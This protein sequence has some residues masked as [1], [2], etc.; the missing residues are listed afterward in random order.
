MSEAKGYALRVANEVWVPR[1]ATE[2]DHDTAW[3][4]MT[5]EERRRTAG[6]IA[7]VLKWT[8][9]RMKHPRL[10]AFL[11]GI[12]YVGMQMIQSKGL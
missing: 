11:D 5:A 2:A 3:A 4:M 1:N 10:A 8:V 7:R 6:Q 9:W 12:A